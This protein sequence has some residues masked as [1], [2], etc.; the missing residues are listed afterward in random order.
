MSE[1]S[2]E[3]KCPGGPCEAC[4]YANFIMTP[5]GWMV[6]CTLWRYKSEK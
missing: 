5:Y 4:Q 3:P 1:D 6:D 2:G